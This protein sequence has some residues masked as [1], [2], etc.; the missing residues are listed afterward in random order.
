MKVKLGIAPIAWSNDDMPELG[1]E[2]T[3]EQCL[4]EAKL[5]GFSGIESGGKFPLDSRILI[6]KLEKENLKLCSGW[7]GAKLL[8]NTAKEEFLK[9]RNQLKLF[10]DCG[11]PCM[12][13]AEVTNSIQS[14]PKRSLSTKPIMDKSD[15][16]RLITRIN[17][18]SKMMLDENMPLA[19]H[20]HMGTVIETQ[21]E[22]ERLI[23][24]TKDSVKL[25]IDTGHMLFAGGDSIKIIENFHERIIHVHTKDMRKEILKKSLKNNVSF[26]QAFL[27]G[28]FTVPGDG[29]IDFEPIIISLKEINY[30]GWIVVEAEQD[31]AKANPLIYAKK[32]YKYLKDLLIK[33]GVE[34]INDK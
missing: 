22:T 11:A 28:A 24:N 12:V 8:K 31:P 32:G 19:Y 27:D 20:H 1:G 33:S 34:I 14:D 18:I 6:P 5:A 9:M 4:S 15:W 10:K 29:C 23:E 26:R 13:F 3:L 2:T 7:Y 21:E 30:N 25:L 17:E 16:S